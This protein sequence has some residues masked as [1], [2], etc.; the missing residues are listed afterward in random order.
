VTWKLVGKPVTVRATNK[1]ATEFSTMDPVPHER[2]LSQRRLEIYKKI[3]DQGAF[4]PV[5]WAKAYC[6]ETNGTYRVNGQHTST[7][8]VLQEGNFPEFYVTVECYACD[9]LTDVAN[10]YNTFD[11]RLQSRSVHDINRSFASTVPSLKYVHDRV[12]HLIVSGVNYHLHGQG[13]NHFYGRI[14]P[15]DRAEVLLEYEGFGVW[16]S[17][18]LE[19]TQE[20]GKRH[21][22]RQPVVAVMFGTWKKD[23]ALASEFWTLVRDETGA[24]PEVPDRRLA[25]YLLT[26]SVG[27]GNRTIRTNVGSKECYVKCIR[28]WNAWRRKIPTDLRYS[29]KDKVPELE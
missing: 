14:T 27:R 20:I 24:T 4:R 10:L 22:M 13:S 3:L 26:H 17:D 8:L 12:I 18:L 16:L 15:A 5:T 19:G 25:R 11:S 29:E 28:A 21:L 7:L 1:L 2:G 23:P 9:T 6:T